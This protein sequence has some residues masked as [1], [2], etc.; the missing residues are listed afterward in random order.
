MKRFLV[1]IAVLAL[2]VPGALLAQDELTLEGL[3]ERFTGLVERVDAVGER[4]AALTVRGETVESMWEGPGAV[5]LD[6]ERCMIGARPNTRDLQD[7]TVLKYKGTYDEWPE[8]GEFH[9]A[10][11]IWM[12]DLE[13]TGVVYRE[14]FK[15]R[16]AMEIWE[17][18]EF[19]GSSD[20][21]IGE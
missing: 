1:I 4:V 10:E 9:V 8:M 13:R 3:A 15:N 16:S 17:G 7:E 14:R 5:M 6:D 18:C 21:W 19:I 2:L 12:A 20:W 11:I